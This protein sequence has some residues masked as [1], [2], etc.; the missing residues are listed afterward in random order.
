VKKKEEEREVVKRKEDNE[1]F[2][3]FLICKL[4]AIGIL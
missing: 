3:Q 2:F 1:Q 4:V